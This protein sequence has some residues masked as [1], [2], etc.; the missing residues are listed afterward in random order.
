MDPEL[1]EGLNSAVLNLHVLRRI[2]KVCKY[3]NV[4]YLSVLSVFS[5]LLYR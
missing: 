5:L 1:V 2:E 4:M 3:H